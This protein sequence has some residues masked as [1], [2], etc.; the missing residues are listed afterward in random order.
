MKDNNNH[1]KLLKLEII[2]YLIQELKKN[3]NGFFKKDNNNNE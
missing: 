3:Y 1:L 2:Y